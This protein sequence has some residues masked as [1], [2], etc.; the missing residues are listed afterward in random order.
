VQ[1]ERARGMG[2]IVTVPFATGKANVGP[3]EVC[4]PGSL[5]PKFWVQFV[6]HERRC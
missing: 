5:L 6:N 4:A 3:A 1:V 2:K